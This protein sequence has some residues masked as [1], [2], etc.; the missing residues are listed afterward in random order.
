MNEFKNFLITGING[1]IGKKLAEELKKRK[2]Y[3]IGLDKNEIYAN[4]YANYKFDIT[5]WEELKK[6]EKKIDCIIHLAAVTDNR[7]ERN[8]IYKVNVSGTSNICKLGAKLNV[9]KIIYLSTV[10]VYSSY[11]K[12]YIDEN[13]QIEPVN[14][15]GE[16][17]YK[18]EEIITNCGINY[19]ILR[20][21]NIFSD[22][23]DKWSEYF[24]RVKNTGKD[25]GILF[26]RN[27]NIHLLFVKD[28]INVVIKCI[29][30]EKSSNNIFIV[31]DNEEYYNE[32]N[33]F[34]VLLNA[35][36]SKKKLLLHPL[37]FFDKKKDIRIFSEQKLLH[38]LNYR[39][40]YGVDS[41]LK[42]RFN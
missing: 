23:E 36:N 12:K 21:T 6:I 13:T 26:Y 40:Q 31:A 39:H 25:F 8:L 17:K 16:T 37:D 42:Q 4:L 28:L 18:A 29:D 11:D 20:P 41:G 35:Y 22:S 7:T 2:Y 10:S 38:T 9:K 15:Y 19:T 33:V 1:F 24:G 32:K 34:K 14:Y 30:D 27:R 5:S 3:V